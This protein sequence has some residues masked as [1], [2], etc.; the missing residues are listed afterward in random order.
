MDNVAPILQ[1]DLELHT[2]TSIGQSLHIMP[3]PA[4][5]LNLHPSFFVRAAS[6]L[7]RQKQP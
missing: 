3:N 1:I 2:K 5:Q 6:A 7:S 4:T